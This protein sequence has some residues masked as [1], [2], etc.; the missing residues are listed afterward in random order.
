MVATFRSGDGP[1]RRS[2]MRVSLPEG[3]VNRSLRGGPTPGPLWVS[4]N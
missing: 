1:R 4:P 3:V 2:P